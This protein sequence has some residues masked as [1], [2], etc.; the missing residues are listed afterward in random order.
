MKGK[1]FKRATAL[2]STA[3]MLLTCADFSA[4]DFSVHAENGDEAPELVSYDV[5][6][7]KTIDDGETAY[8]LDSA[9]DLYWFAEK[10][11]NDNANY[12]SANAFLACDITVNTGV[13]DKNGNFNEA[14]FGNFRAWTPIGYYNDKPFITS[15]PYKGI[16][17][18]AG[19]RVSGLYFYNDE[20]HY[21]GLF[22]Y[23]V[24]G[25][26]K[27]V[28]VADSYFYGYWE[29]GGVCG[30]N[31]D[32]AI[33]NCCNEGEIEGVYAIGGICGYTEGST[34]TDCSN[35]GRVTSDS[36]YN[37]RVGGICGD[38]GSTVTGCS[39]TG[40]IGG[41]NCVGGICGRND[42]VFGH[43]EI[44]D[45]FNSGKVTSGGMRYTDPK[46]VPDGVKNAGGICGYNYFGMVA[47][48]SNTGEI[49]GAAYEYNNYDDDYSGSIGIGGVC[50]HNE[51]GTLENCHSTGKV[52]G[53]TDIGGVCGENI[54]TIKKCS[55]AGEIK[56]F[57]V[58]SLNL[59][60]IKTSKNIGGVCGYCNSNDGYDGLIKNCY[61]TGEVSGY[62]NAGGVC[63]YI[64]EGIIVNCYNTG[65]AFATGKDQ[66]EGSVCAFNENGTIENCYFLNTAAGD[67]YAKAMS[68]EQFA[69]GEV[70]WLLNGG[71]SDKP[72]FYQ[73]L[74]SPKDEY[75]VLDK[76]HIVIKDGESYKND[77][78]N[79]ENGICTACGA[80]EDGMGARLAGASLSL[81]GSIG[82]NFYMQLA[83]D[84]IA[85][86]NAY[87]LF[88][89]PNGVTSEIKVSDAE[90]AN[91]G[92]MTYYV[93]KCNV[94][95]TEMT[96]TIKAQIKTSSGNGI[97]YS[98]SVKEYADYLLAHI[99]ENAEYAKAEELVRTMLNYGAYAQTFKKY[100]TDILPCETSDVSEYVINE[101]GYTAYAGTK[102]EFAGANLSML[103][104][105]TLRLFFKADDITDV[106]FMNG[107]K[108]LEIGKNNVLY[109]VEI[110]N[111]T[112]DKL[113]NDFTVSISDGG[114]VTY[115]PMTYCYQV[116]QT[117]NDAALVNLVKAIAQ[118]NDAAEAYFKEA[119][120]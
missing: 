5:N 49:Y 105:T 46:D 6:G 108:E 66:P 33:E 74:E 106:K 9:D 103:S 87:L 4:I 115:S 120:V 85:D 102:V 43:G 36:P 69:N 97:E 28:T 56:G 65:D 81:D 19:Y 101:H 37:S 13:L 40:L 100:N 93:F 42:K 18:G 94:A 76:H 16:F 84:V 98:Y 47:N 51:W 80:F 82:V 89:L 2:L 114:L 35:Q 20:Q 52:S 86:E 50:G 73:N 34:I 67:S 10:V 70:C 48:C 11:K 59:L 62:A 117:S 22:G 116:S 17:D 53:V 55:N 27:N 78:H 31:E 63:A 58:G 110:A 119:K 15:R 88:T 118:Y 39:N 12:G 75:P 21:V 111:I 113:S 83:D 77:A 7:D 68:A 23:V 61:N 79:Y 104:N 57:S 92:D 109:F 3:A 95:A 60:H 38:N 99:T 45:C 91:V 64:T 26:I 24:G 41:S 25:T 107:A 30:I 1:R 112:P 14:E 32:G 72:V 90:K 8:R 71:R 44:T 54:G 29:V 96:D